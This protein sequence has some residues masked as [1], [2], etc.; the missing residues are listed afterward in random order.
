MNPNLQSPDLGTDASGAPLPE[1][2]QDIPVPNLDEIITE[3]DTPV[4]SIY[5]EKQQRLLTEPLYSS[6]NAPEESRPFLA[7]AN[8]GLFYQFKEPPLVPDALL[9]LRAAVGADLHLK[10]NHSYFVWMQGK[11]P[12]EV[13]EIVS[14]RS[15]GEDSFKLRLYAAIGVP[16]YAI[17][18]PRGMLEGGPLRIYALQEGK[19]ELMDSGWLPHVGLGLKLWQG[20]FEGQPETWLRWCDRDGNVIPTGAERAEEERRRADEEHRRADEERRRAED[21][22][23]RADRLAAQ[24][25]ALGVEPEA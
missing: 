2:M 12:N 24:L 11:P 16:Y 9:A 20:T 8:V 18:D 22:I 4:D 15:G 23:A 5:T 14:D 3:D 1:W 13:T 21:T 25:R 7:L 10:A 6:W 17:Y 19:Y